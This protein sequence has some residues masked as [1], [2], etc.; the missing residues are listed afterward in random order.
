MF[1]TKAK[2]TLKKIQYLQ[3]ITG[4]E[5]EKV[6]NNISR[7]LGQLEMTNVTFIIK[8]PSAQALN[9]RAYWIG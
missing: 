7:L 4:K 8:R 5:K 9:V 1:C 6:E 2:P 3:E